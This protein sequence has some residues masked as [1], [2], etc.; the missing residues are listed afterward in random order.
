MKANCITF[1]F[2][3]LLTGLFT[4]FTHEPII[5]HPSDTWEHLGTRK[6]NYSLEKD[7]IMVTAAE[8]SLTSLKLKVT[9]GDLNMHRMVVVYGNGMRDEIELRHH[10]RHRSSSRIIDLN[11]NNRIIKQVIFWYDTKNYANHRATIHLYG[12]H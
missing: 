3:L 4:S 2:G 9:G 10:F 6:I 7:H 1:F 5:Y 11:G 12:R 8:G